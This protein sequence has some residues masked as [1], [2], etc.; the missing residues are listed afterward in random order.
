VPPL[1]PACTR[2]DRSVEEITREKAILSFEVVRSLVSNVN[3]QPG[4][5]ATT[6]RPLIVDQHVDPG[7]LRRVFDEV[8]KQFGELRSKAGKAARQFAKALGNHVEGA[9]QIRERWLEMERQPE[10]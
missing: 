6:L 2:Y 10:S 4:T 1:I 5:A 7:M 3:A 8:P 9:A